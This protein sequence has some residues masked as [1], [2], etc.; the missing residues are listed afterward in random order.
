MVVKMNIKR[1]SWKIRQSLKNKM[2]LDM[3]DS[4]CVP[5]G[6]IRISICVVTQD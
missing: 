3:V 5:F 6:M 1:S 4:G 2:S